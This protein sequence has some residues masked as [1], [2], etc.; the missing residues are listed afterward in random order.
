MASN[1]VKEH[2]RKINEH[3]HISRSF[4]QTI[5]ETN[6]IPMMFASQLF[7]V[8]GTKQRLQVGNL[9]DKFMSPLSLTA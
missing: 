4:K 7:A 9:Y 3:M 2:D 8:F 1:T 5:E 6:V